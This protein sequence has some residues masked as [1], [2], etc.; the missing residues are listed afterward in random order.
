MVCQPGGSWDHTG[1]MAVGWEWEEE[2][3]LSSSC[4]PASSQALPL[5]APSW[6]PQSLEDAAAQ[7]GISTLRHAYPPSNSFVVFRQIVY[8]LSHQGSLF[9]PHGSPVPLV[10]WGCPLPLTFL[11]LQQ[12]WQL[13]TSDYSSGLPPTAPPKINKKEV[14]KGER[15]WFRLVHLHIWSPDRNL[16]S[17]WEM[18]T[19]APVT[20]Q[21]TV[22]VSRSQRE[23]CPMPCLENWFG[24]KVDR[25]QGLASI[26]HSSGYCL[27]YL[28]K[29]FISTFVI[30][31]NPLLVCWILQ[32]CC[33]PLFTTPPSTPRA[34]FRLYF[35]HKGEFVCR[36][37][38][39]LCSQPSV[40]IIGHIWCP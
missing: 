4:P 30:L 10:S 11:L 36:T 29:I 6:Q 24:N 39:P 25:P 18:E 8:R 9:L 31:S 15:K 17:L 38:L 19:G 40:C 5:T 3:F 35:S 1:D 34:L 32:G 26:T 20:P 33:L 12:V 23:H 13:F 22:S 28:M 37:C 21:R 27:V 14:C 16:L 2:I 7:H